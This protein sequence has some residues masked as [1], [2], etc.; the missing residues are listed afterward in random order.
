MNTQQA[1]DAWSATYDTV[2]NHT[3]DLEAA[4]IRTMVPAALGITPVGRCGHII[5]LGCGTGKNTHWL[6][7]QTER[8]TAVDFS[9][10]MLAQARTK[11]LRSNVAFQQADI[12]Q[13]W[14]FAET[15]QADLITC[16]LILE[17]IDDLDF[18]FAEAARALAPGGLLYVGEL[19]P[20]KQYQGSKA[21]F[22]T[23]T[24]QMRELDCYIHHLTDYTHAARYAGLTVEALREWFDDT[25]ETR[26]GP[27]RIVAWVFRKE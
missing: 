26:T 3:R 16:S 23:A 17:H 11:T 27:P 21:R 10:E 22:E 12:T 7:M 5:E 13:P 8:L 15:G 4:A 20:F 24:G 1:Y 14:A 25:D 2:E 19:H 18:V 9:T 6:A